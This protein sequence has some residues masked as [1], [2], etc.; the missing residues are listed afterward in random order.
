MPSPPEKVSAPSLA[1]RLS[2]T[3][4]PGPPMLASLPSPPINSSF[5]SSPKRSSLPSVPAR[6]SSPGPPKTS[7][8]PPPATTRSLPLPPTRV[9]RTGPP[10]S[11]S[12]PSPPKRNPLPVPVKVTVSLP[13][14]PARLKFPRRV[15]SP[16]PPLST[17]CGEEAPELITSAAEPPCTACTSAP[18]LS[19]SPAAPS[20]PTPSRVT[21]TGVVRA[22]YVARSKSPTVPEELPTK[23]SRPSGTASATIVSRPGPPSSRSSPGPRQTVSS[24]PTAAT[25]SLPAPAEMT[26]LPAVPMRASLPAV[27]V[28]VTGRPL[29]VSAAWAGAA[30]MSSAP[31]SPAAAR[32]AFLTGFL[33]VVV[34]SARPA[35][36]A[37][38]VR[39]GTLHRRAR[40]LLGNRWERVDALSGTSGAGRH[41]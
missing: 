26:S 15:S 30:G 19:P 14:S 11:T 2:A 24:P 37:P 8:S 5:P 35:A 28:I 27:P 40:Q 4:S 12:A 23:T 38:G 29:H 13:A 18:M 25:M 9:S 1:T 10:L 6:R 3:S 33:P 31:N 39:L 17:V 36:G 22:A 34:V 7:S 41:G 20:L 21:V 16:A 32:Y